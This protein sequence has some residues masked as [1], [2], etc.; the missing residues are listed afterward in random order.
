MLSL[1]LATTNTIV[2]SWNQ[3]LISGTHFNSF[4][5]IIVDTEVQDSF[6]HIGTLSVCSRHQYTGSMPSINMEL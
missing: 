6:I 2:V 4:I 5:L 3:N 1:H